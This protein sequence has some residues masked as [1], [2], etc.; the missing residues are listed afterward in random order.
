[1]Q[2]LTTLS[3]YIIDIKMYHD[4]CLIIRMTSWT[5]A[6]GRWRHVKLEKAQD[7]H[8]TQGVGGVQVLYKMV[9]EP[10]LGL[11]DVEEVTSGAAEAVDHI[12]RC[13]GEPLSSVEGLF[14]ALNE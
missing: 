5:L 10:P 7:G 1:M 4:L 2:N 12:E 3:T 6:P 9:S 14:C 8:V 13:A 11:S